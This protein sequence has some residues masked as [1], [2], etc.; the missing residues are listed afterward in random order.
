MFSRRRS[1]RR[2][3]QWPLEPAHVEA[4]G[5]ACEGKETICGFKAP[6][7]AM[8]VGERMF[9]GGGAADEAF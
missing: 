5:K 7:R 2:L 6:E 3:Q 1:E 9:T 4:R 8:G